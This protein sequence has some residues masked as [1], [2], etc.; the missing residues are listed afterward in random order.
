MLREVWEPALKVLFVGM[1]VDETSDKLGFHHLHPRDRF[2]DLLE[3]GGFTPKKLISASERKALAEGQAKGNLSDPIRVMFIEK[4]VSQLSKLGIGLTDLNR[5]VIASNDKDKNA[6]PIAQDIEEFIGKV[7]ALKPQALAFLLRP[8][9]FLD[10][11][12]SRYPT[13]SDALGLQPFMIDKA[14]I[15]LLGSP[16]AVLRGEGLTRQEDAFF[17]LGE[18]IASQS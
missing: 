7:T 6:L 10:L 2:W 8:E 1:A 12:R 13:V 18:R 16:V 17:A 4:K 5:R 11:F 3:M 14:E 9:L 15:W